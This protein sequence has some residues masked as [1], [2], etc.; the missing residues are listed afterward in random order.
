MYRIRIVFNAP[1]DREHPFYSVAKRTLNEAVQIV[2]DMRPAIV[3]AVSVTM[4]TSGDEGMHGQWRTMLSDEWR[5]LVS[6]ASV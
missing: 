6:K 3:H 2:E 5:H 1:V 4:Q